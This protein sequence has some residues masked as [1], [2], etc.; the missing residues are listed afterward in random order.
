MTETVKNA[1]AKVEN[2]AI[3]NKS[4]LSSSCCLRTFGANLSRWTC[5]DRT[6]LHLVSES[7]ISHGRVSDA[8][9]ST[10][11]CRKFCSVSANLSRPRQYRSPSTSQT[12]SRDWSTTPATDNGHQQRHRFPRQILPIPQRNL[13]NSAT[14]HGAIIPKYPTFRSQLALLY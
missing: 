9:S 10:Q 1:L 3:E 11:L 13:W 6:S 4:I 2:K 12:L 8:T 14:F 5:I 7:R